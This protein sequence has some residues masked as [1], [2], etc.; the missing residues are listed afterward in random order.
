[1]QVSCKCNCLQVQVQVQVSVPTRSGRV[2]RL[3]YKN[4][5]DEAGWTGLPLVAGN[6]GIRVLSD[7]TATAA[8]RLYRVRHW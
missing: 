2:Y 4:A 8:Q 1:M 3:E 5:L 6:G 7:P